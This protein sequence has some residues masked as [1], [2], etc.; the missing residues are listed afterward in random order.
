MRFSIVI[1]V[2]NVKEYLYE[3]VH[4]VLVQNFY[5]YELILV[6]DGSTDGSGDLCQSIEKENSEIQ[7][8][9]IHKQ[10]GGLDSA[11]KAGFQIAKGYYIIFLD[12]DDWMAPGQLAVI[13][14]KL[15]GIPQEADIVQTAYTVVYADGKKRLVNSFEQIF[16]GEK[17]ISG[18]A[19]LYNEI[20][21][22]VSMNSV[23][24]KIYRKEFLVKANIPVLPKYSC[25]D[26][27]TMVK[28]A[29]YGC[30][31]AYLDE[32]MIMFRSG[33]T[34]SITTHMNG[35]YIK[36]YIDTI[37]RIM[38]EL[39]LSDFD[40]GNVLCSKLAGSCLEQYQNIDELPK[41]EQQAIYLYAKANNEILDEASG[42]LSVLYKV[43]GYKF[44][45]KLIRLWFTLYQVYY[46]HIGKVIR[47]K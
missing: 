27:E 26:V 21:N 23:W 1:P 22:G 14:E 9:V 12:S 39:K 13:N 7:I 35:N 5:D 43:L 2:Y 44:G 37:Q 47:E 30:K 11:R 31:I 45:N 20:T 40:K 34:G 25:E 38:I 18:E 46:D 32:N 19:F 17:V 36:G 33:R 28:C 24:S 6:D 4:S 29:I 8:Q 3:C 16:A 10:N 41:D 15:S 42:L